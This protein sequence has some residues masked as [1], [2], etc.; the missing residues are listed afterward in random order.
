MLRTRFVVWCVAL[1]MLTVA[2]SG[3]PALHAAS[4]GGVL[5]AV[6]VPFADNFEATTLNQAWL[7]STAGKGV[8]EITADYAQSGSRSVFIGQKTAGDASAEL[9]LPVDLT[10]Q[11][12]VY[13]DFW[14]R[15]TGN[16]GWSSTGV[17]FSDNDGTTWKR[18]RELADFSQT[19]NHEVLNVANL[20]TVNGLALNDKFRI[21]IGFY[22]RAEDAGDGLVIDDLRV[23]NANPISSV[24]LPLLKRR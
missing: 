11:S 7:T 10:G 9:V 18:V 22:D 12:D 13:L 17:W 24:Y 19:F 8:V 15:R 1:L 16:T 5:Q 6:G 14:V 21:L 3:T 23:V 20:A 2:W 4:R